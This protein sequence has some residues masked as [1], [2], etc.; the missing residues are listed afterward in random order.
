[1]AI[2]PAAK[3]ML[4]HETRA[5]LAR[6]ALVKPFAL[7]ETMLP[8]A[9][10]LPAS[11]LAIDKFLIAGRKELRRLVHR[12]LQWLGGEGGA[13][14]TA[15]QAQAR[16]TI[17]RLKFNSVLT[18]F[19]LFADVITQRSE[20]E[21]GVWLSG[22]DVVASDALALPDYYDPPPVICYVDRDIGAAI[23]RARTRLPGSGENPVAIVRVPR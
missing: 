2:G 14:A 16:F 9:A 18:Q 6:L 17:L 10:L 7:Q 21:T 15:A 8:A 22:L 4:V 20:S 23:R 3:A 1:M 5:L 12:F 19:D 13:E 11:Q